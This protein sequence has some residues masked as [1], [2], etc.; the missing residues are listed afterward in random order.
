MTPIVGFFAASLVLAASTASA[1]AITVTKFLSKAEKLMNAGVG[2]SFPS[3]SNQSWQKWIG[4]Q[5]DIVLISSGSRS[6]KANVKPST[7][8]RKP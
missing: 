5:R 1:S 3:T 8:E 7:K 2:P 4:L 6:R